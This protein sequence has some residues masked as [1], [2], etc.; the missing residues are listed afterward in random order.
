MASS[1]TADKP[2]QRRPYAARVPADVRREQLLDAALMVIVRDGYDAVSV[3][4]IAREAG[5]TRPVVYGVFDG[6][7]P[8][9]EALLDRQQ[10]RAL[11][12]LGEALPAKPDLSDPDRLVEE[13]AR[14]LI[15]VVRSDPMT[16]RPILFAQQG[17]PEQ[18]RARIDADRENFLAQVT[19]L[20]EIGLVLRGGPAVDA[21]VAAHAVLAVLE[22]F[23]RLL[24]TEPDRFDTD[25]LV[26]TLTGLLKAVR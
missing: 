5:V 1:S 12:Q 13:T 11:A 8:L 18:A 26:G 10:A 22:H 3:D 20:I 17:M 14:R 23:G 7:R 6:L 9:L 21:E 16:W 19:G 15:D 24:L 25:R 4:A 2:R